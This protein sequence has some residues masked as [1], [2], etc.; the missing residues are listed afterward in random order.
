MLQLAKEIVA[1]RR[2]TAEDDLT[3]LI[4]ADLSELCQGADYIRKELCGNRADLCS[5]INGRGGRCSENCKFCAQSAHH[6]THCDEYAFLA[7]DEFVADCMKTAAKGV[8]RYSIV[9]AGRTLKGADL[10]LAIDAYKAMHAA[11]PDMILCASHGLMTEEDLRRLIK[12]CLRARTKK[13]RSDGQEPPDS[14]CA[15]EA[16]SVWARPGRTASTW[17]SC[18]QN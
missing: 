17:H 8:D 15:A 10:E 3:R 16:S 1:G 9:T 6:S 14:P 5:I 2:L 12:I 18:S 4:T 13:K 7:T 11:C